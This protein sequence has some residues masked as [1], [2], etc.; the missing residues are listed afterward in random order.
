MIRQEDVVLIGRIT[1]AHGL[2]GEVVFTFTDDVFDRVDCD[3]LICDIDGILVPFFIEEYRFRSNGSALMKFEDIDTVEQTAQIVGSDVFFPKE[4]M[5]P[6]EEG[7][8]SLNSFVGFHV[9]DKEMGDIGIVRDYD[10]Q[11]EN[12][13]LKVENE[14]GR[15]LLLPFHDD[16]ITHI[17][18]ENG[19]VEMQLPE[20]L[21]E[22]FQ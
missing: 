12:W 18:F 15:Q 19:L 14:Q 13:L 22:L 17:D 5:P 2:A 3:Y 1:K 10:D 16:F 6:P 21:L 11:T 4:L 8:L 20:G 7:D 9:F